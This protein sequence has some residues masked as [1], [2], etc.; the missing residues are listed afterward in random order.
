MSNNHVSGIIA[1]SPLEKGYDMFIES[2]LYGAIL[3]IS[4][5]TIKR[6]YWYG[7]PTPLVFIVYALV[8]HF[9]LYFGFIGSQSGEWGGAFTM[10]GGTIAAIIAYLH[11]SGD[12]AYYRQTYPKPPKLPARVRGPEDHPDWSSYRQS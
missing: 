9:V 8:L 10:M 6:I 11:L 1:L 5:L 2:M 4:A 7:K 3:C 12:I